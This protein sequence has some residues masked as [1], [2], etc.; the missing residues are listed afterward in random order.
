[1]SPSVYAVVLNHNG[2]GWLKRC[3]ESLLACSYPTLRVLLVDNASTDDSLQV[4]R[5]FSGRLH[6][7]QNSENLGFCEGNNLAIRYALE[8]GADYVALLNNDTWF[9][10]EWLDSL[11]AV[12]ERNPQVGILGPVQFCFDSQEFNTWTTSALPHLLDALRQPAGPEA[13]FPVEWVEGSCLV[14]KRAVFER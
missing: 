13:W 5:E 8:H 3:L 6:L 12:G 2:A 7:L 1:M 10:P 4:V 9:E 11:V 14:A